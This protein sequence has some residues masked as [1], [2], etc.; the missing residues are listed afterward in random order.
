MPEKYKIGVMKKI[1]AIDLDKTLIPF[2]SFR[3]L[4]FSY[5][6]QKNYLTLL[7]F[8]LLLRKMRLIGSGEFKYR[9]LMILRK[10]KQYQDLLLV[11]VKKVMSAIRQ[12]IIEAIDQETDADTI[13][14]LISASPTDYVRLVA[15]ELNW[16]CLGSKIENGKFIHCYGLKK[17]ELLLTNYPREKLLYNFAISDSA[18]DLPMLQ[19]FRRHKLVSR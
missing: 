8:Y 6:K 3:I 1:N 5:L 4:I 16:P 2:D 14:V 10:D 13:N 17:K 18:S 11:L 7:V 9:A 12:D 19:M 15:E